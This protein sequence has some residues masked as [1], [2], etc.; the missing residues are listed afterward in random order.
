MEIA[1]KLGPHLSEFY[2]VD[3]SGLSPLALQSVQ[4][5]ELR[6]VSQA[7]IDVV[8]NSFFDPIVSALSPFMDHILYIELDSG[9]QEQSESDRK[10]YFNALYTRLSSSL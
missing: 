8:G 9:K 4:K 10:A 6:T 1:I 7:F 3:G 2:Q 5:T